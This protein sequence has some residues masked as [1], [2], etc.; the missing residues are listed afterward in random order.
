[1]Q[2]GASFWSDDYT[3]GEPQT[4]PRGQYWSGDRELSPL[5]TL[6]G[7]ASLN[8]TWRADGDSR[9]VGVFRELSAGASLDLLATF[10]RDFTW[11][12]KKPDDTVVLLP[13]LG[14][15]GSF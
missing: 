7:G 1:V 9:W 15:T 8:G 10:L 4:G 3:G 11:A 5:Q 14:A 13:S 6:L 12:G 2:S